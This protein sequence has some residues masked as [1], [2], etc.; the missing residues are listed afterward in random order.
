MPENLVIEQSHS[1]PWSKQT[2]SPLFCYFLSIY[3][4]LYT[5]LYLY[6]YIYLSIDLYISI[7]LHTYLTIFARKSGYRTITFWSM[8]QG[9]TNSIIFPFSIYLSIFLS[10]YLTIYLPIYLS[11][12]IPISQYLPENLV[13][14]QSH[15]DP[16]YTKSIILPFS[17]YLYLYTCLSFYL[18]T[19]LSHNICQKT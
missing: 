9:D 16:W 8:I 14:E 13:I 2:Q 12:Y 17:I 19:Y 6:L 11:I 1:D 10:I 4:Y 5:C 3:L 15:S 18:S 7:Y